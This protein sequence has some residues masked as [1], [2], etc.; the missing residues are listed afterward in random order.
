MAVSTEAR[1]APQATATMTPSLQEVPI[2]ISAFVPS[3]RATA[4]L[5]FSRYQYGSTGGTN[6]TVYASGPVV[7]TLTPETVLL[8]E[9][10][11]T[12]TVVLDYSTATATLEQTAIYVL[13][14]STIYEKDY[15]AAGLEGAF[16]HAPIE[17]SVVSTRIR[18]ASRHLLQHRK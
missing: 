4:P 1:P 12:E 18:H 10:K 2:T 8:T 9:A 17:S 13:G 3:G 16:R 11:T 7:V 6:T 15:Y 14:P 5:P